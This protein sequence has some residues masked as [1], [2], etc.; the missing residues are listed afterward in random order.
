MNRATGIAIMLIVCASLPAL[1]QPDLEPQLPLEQRPGG[2]IIF[3]RYIT[4]PIKG[5]TE[6]IVLP[7][8]FVM[9]ADGANARAFFTPGGYASAKE[10]RWSPDYD[11]LVF[12]SDYM[13]ELSACVD[14][15]WV[16]QADGSRCA[17]VTGG[18]VPFVAAYG[19]VTGEVDISGA[20]KGRPTVTHTD[21]NIAAAGS[22]LIYHPNPD[23]TFEIPLVAAGEK[24]WFK[25]WASKYMGNVVARE[26]L[27]NLVNDVGKIRLFGANLLAGKGSITPD[28]RYVIGMGGQ[29][30]V[31]DAAGPH[32]G[33]EDQGW[34]A[35]KQ[36]TVG[37]AAN[38]AIYDVAMGGIISA[39]FQATAA[40][41]QDAKDPV[42]SP[43]GRT[44][45][46]CWGR[47]AIQNLAIMTIAEMLAD[48]PNPQVI[49]PGQT[50]FPSAATGFQSAMISA[51]SPAWRPD[52]QALA[53]CKAVMTTQLITGEINVVNRDGSGLQQITNFGPNSLCC[54]PCFSPDG[55]RVAFTVL[56]GNFGPIKPE[57]FAMRQ[58]TADIYVV[59][60]DGSQLQRL[61]NDGMSA[62]PAWGP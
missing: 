58:Y 20:G 37:G 3:S 17:R 34:K 31:S 5:T 52:G 8:L 36:L 11:Q 47:D 38:V 22:D 4:Q 26:V 32:L 59:N 51:A 19:A 14:D 53:F 18:E 56:T 33:P 42:A 61:T 35:P 60:S 41:G 45:A 15:L 23:F 44:F 40:L 16:A 54:Q 55:R 57:H 39:M 9:N 2:S 25:L 1:A 6:K 21:I 49:V 28:G 62:E 10:A 48:R 30:A 7:R 50:I 46:V 12:T 27:P 24:V 43:D 13:E 29:Q